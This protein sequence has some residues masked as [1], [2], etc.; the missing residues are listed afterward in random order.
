MAKNN[1]QTTKRRSRLVIVG[2]MHG[3]TRRRT[4]EH[5]SQVT[6]KERSKEKEAAQQR[7]VACRLGKYA[8]YSHVLFYNF[9]YKKNTHHL[10]A[11][12]SKAF[13]NR[14]VLHSEFRNYF[15]L[16]FSEKKRVP[17][18]GIFSVLHSENL[19]RLRFQG[20]PCKTKW[21]ASKGLSRIRES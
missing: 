13:V 17:K 4:Q 14:E 5:C 15:R 16:C 2:T 6:G 20:L 12:S 9:F 21:R 18:N 1:H 8:K 10:T 7:F 3:V 19:I 11:Q